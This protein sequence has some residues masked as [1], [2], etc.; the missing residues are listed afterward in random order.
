M[1]EIEVCV[2]V[3]MCLCVCVSVC[4]C[5]CVCVCSLTW[6]VPSP[7]ELFLNHLLVEQTAHKHHQH[8]QKVH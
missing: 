2:C 6:Y 3:C 5:V 7:Q 4:M 1:K 8:I